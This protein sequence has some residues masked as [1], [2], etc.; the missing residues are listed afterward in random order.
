MFVKYVYT[1]NIMIVKYVFKIFLDSAKPKS[2]WIKIT[3]FNDRFQSYNGGVQMFKNMRVV[4]L[5]D[6]LLN[7]GLK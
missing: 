3:F 7:V 2:V 6:M 4:I 1:L 5:F